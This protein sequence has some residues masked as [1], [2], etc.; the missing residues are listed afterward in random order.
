MYIYI[1]SSCPK[2]NLI[3]PI[4]SCLSMPAKTSN[5]QATKLTL[6]LGG[7]SY[8]PPGSAPPPSIRPM[9]MH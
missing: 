1:F 7:S 8:R 9:Y 3:H 2:A 5:S 4:K 6:L